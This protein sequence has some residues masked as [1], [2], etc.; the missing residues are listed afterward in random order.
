MSF[1]QNVF[2]SFSCNIVCK[3]IVCEW[4]QH[5]LGWLGDHLKLFWTLN[6][7][8]IA[9]ISLSKSMKCKIALY[10]QGNPVIRGLGIR[11]FGIWFECFEI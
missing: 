9:K 8:K 7:T 1:Y 6:E 10:V 4:E 11:G 3:N 5:F 2:L